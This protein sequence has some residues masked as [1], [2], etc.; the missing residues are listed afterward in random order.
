MS[1]AGVSQVT[2]SHTAV[3]MATVI[4]SDQWG[5]NVTPICWSTSN[6]AA[7]TNELAIAAIS[8]HALIRHQNQ[9]S[10]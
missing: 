7:R 1:V 5:A 9:R 2:A 4:R 8:L 10:R 3:V 6:P